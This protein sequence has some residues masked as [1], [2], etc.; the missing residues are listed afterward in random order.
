MKKIDFKKPFYVK[1]GIGLAL[2]GLAML[3]LH[4]TVGLAG[5][6]PFA[7]PASVALGFAMVG[8]TTDEEE[9]QRLANER[10]ALLDEIQ[11]NVKKEVETRVS[12]Q[13]L[14][15][16]VAN[17][18]K[19]FEGI[20]LDALKLLMSADK[21]VMAMLVKQGAEITALK[22]NGGGQ[23]EDMSIRGQVAAW[24]T[25]NK[26]VIQKVKG[27]QKVD[28]PAFVLKAATSPMT[29][30]NSLN[31][32]AYLPR[33]EFEAGLHDIRRVEP[34]FWDYLTKGR[35]SQASYVWV[36]KTNP[37]GAAAF[38]GAGVAKPGISFELTTE[39]SNA[40][41]IAASEKIA[42][43][44]LDDID[45]MTSF[46]INELVYQ[47]K[48][49]LNTE[50]MTSV[51]STTKVAGIQTISVPF[52]LT[53]IDTDNPNNFDAIRAIVAQLRTG[54]FNGPITVFINPVDAANMDL[55]KATTSG[56]YLLP[57]F[58]TANGKVVAGAT[59]VEDNNVTVG[60]VQA[61]QLDLYR[62]L[63]YQDFAIQWGW[64]NDDFT[65]NLVTV[66]GEM[67]I[68]QFYSAKDAGAFIYD[69]FARI[70]AYITA[71]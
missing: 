44:L 11:K 2:F 52:T 41:K 20:E 49:K 25:K 53:G 27:G 22:E 35:T 23:K 21:G 4:F 64:E 14:K 32:S 7:A 43:E 1:T 12:K 55:V 60:R 26:D 71:S 10:K 62:V 70:K 58:S 33:P 65:K 13:E 63:I 59:I 45:G 61:A 57:P 15:D 30:A 38:I 9:T 69:T 48:A 29:P 37:Q 66:I 3:V 50:L 18:M 24:Q 68:H 19:S 16:E 56:T 5:L 46:V 34:T 54:F 28:L 51:S 36:N 47:V 17:V 67:R 42:I 31:S 40:K 39:I 8:L 6:L